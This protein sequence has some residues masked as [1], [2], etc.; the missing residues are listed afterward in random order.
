MENPVGRMLD[1]CT[2][3]SE[4]PAAARL[5]PRL[6]KRFPGFAFCALLDSRYCSETGFALC[7]ANDWPF[8]ITLTEGV[9]PSVSDEFQALRALTPENRRTDATLP[10]GRRATKHEDR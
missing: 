3:D 1:K 2:Q 8:L 5:L 10:A 9:L 7:E 6:K 4:L